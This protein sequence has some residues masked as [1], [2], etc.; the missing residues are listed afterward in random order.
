MNKIEKNQVGKKVG[1]YLYIHISALDTL[2]EEQQLYIISVIL[3][4]P[5]E[6]FFNVIKLNLKLTDVSFIYSPDFDTSSEPYI[7]NSIKYNGKFSKIR[8]ESIEN[9]SVYHGKGLM[10][11]D[12]YKKFSKQE[13]IDRYNSWQHLNLDKKRIGRKKYWEENILLLGENNV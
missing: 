3:K 11:K 4:L 10:V 5:T 9:P 2:T 6:V 13:S 7:E 8:K 12:D 1:N